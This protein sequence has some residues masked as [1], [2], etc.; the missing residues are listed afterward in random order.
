MPRKKTSG[1]ELAQAL[2]ILDKAQK[3]WSGLAAERER[4]LVRVS[5]ID[6][7]LGQLPGGD[8]APKAQ[9]ARRGRPPKKASAVS[10]APAAAP[11]KPGRK[12][13]GSNGKRTVGEVVLAA[14][15]KDR[16]VA[17]SDILD[18]VVAER[19]DVSKA[20]VGPIV[21]KL[22]EKGLVKVSGPARDYRYTLGG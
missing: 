12:P 19:P 8:A 16:P 17:W 22:R 1:G 3:I 14:L 7:V 4:L 2:A 11:R 20:S 9:P 6:A 15:S 5:E 13:G 10:A 18:K 21:A